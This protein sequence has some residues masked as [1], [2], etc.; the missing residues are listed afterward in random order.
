VA[1]VVVTEQALRSDDRLVW[2]TIIVRECEGGVRGN[3]NVLQRKTV[4]NEKQ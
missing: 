1:G 3:E 2:Y 4:E